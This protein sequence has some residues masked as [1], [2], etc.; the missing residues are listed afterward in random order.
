MKRSQRLQGDIFFDNSFLRYV[1]CQ[2]IG[3]FMADPEYNDSA[4]V[5]MAGKS[6]AVR[7][8]RKYRFDE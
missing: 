5:F 8:P 1:G 4:K 2:K 7:I 6:Q 3:G